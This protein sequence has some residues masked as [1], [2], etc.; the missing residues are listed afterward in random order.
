MVDHGNLRHSTSFFGAIKI[1]YN[2]IQHQNSDT[3]EI[4]TENYIATF[5]TAV[6]ASAGS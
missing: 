1:G 3:A 6:T 5:Q 4:I 2:I